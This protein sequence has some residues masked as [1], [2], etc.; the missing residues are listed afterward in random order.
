[1]SIEL[2]SI[3]ILSLMLMGITFIQGGLTP[4]IHGFGW[5]LG[6]RDTPVE[7]TAIQNRFARTVQN[8]IEAMLIYIPLMALTVFLERT[9]ELTEIAAWLVII[10]RAA[11]IACYLFG[12]F[13]LRSLAYTTAT[14]GS[15][16]TVWALFAG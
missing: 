15:L 14:V 5:G 8:Q 10:G 7:Q 9:S 4:L 2:G 1:M 11:F 6:S 12:V 16:M 3:A 13:G